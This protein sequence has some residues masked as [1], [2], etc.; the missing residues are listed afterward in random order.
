[1]WGSWAG[2]RIVTD[3]RQA[4][5]VRHEKETCAQNGRS[6]GEDDIPHCEEEE[7]ELAARIHSL[8][9][10]RVMGWSGSMT[11]SGNIP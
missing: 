4:S 10:E 9:C 5:S 6:H 11:S 3:E 1:M 7:V 8:R 2:G